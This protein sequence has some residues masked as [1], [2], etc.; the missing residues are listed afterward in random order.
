M[1][2]VEQAPKN[3]ARIVGFDTLTKIDA[4]AASRLSASGLRFAV[5]Y[6]ALG[7]PS[8]VTLDAVE[9]E[10][11]TSAGLGVMAVQFARTSGW[12]ATTGEADG[13][14]AARNALAAGMPPETTLWC[15]LEGA[16]PNAG[17]ALDYAAAWYAAA[18]KEGMGD[19]GVYVGAGFAPPV[20]ESVLFHALPFRRYWRSLSAVPNVEQRGYQMVQLFPANQII[21][22]VQVDLD[23]VQ[24]D[25]FGDRPRWAAL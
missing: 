19:P 12:T 11:L 8:R 17:A 10:F 22:G 4:D 2:R 23:V 15:D 21:E 6:V 16:L 13:R 3:T 20:T 14:W 24:S 1:F 7:A 5:R 25:Y 9:L 18:T